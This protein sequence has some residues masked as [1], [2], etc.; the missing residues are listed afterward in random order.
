M[1]C[2]IPTYRDTQANGIEVEILKY[3]CNGNSSTWVQTAF[4]A[5]NKREPIKETTHPSAFIMKC[6]IGKHILYSFES[7][8]I[9]FYQ[10]LLQASSKQYQ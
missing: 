6:K 2:R 10:T 8:T 9:V 1:I 4:E 7:P 3:P 5:A